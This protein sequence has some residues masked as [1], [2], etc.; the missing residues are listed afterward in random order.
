[1]K[2]IVGCWEKGE[3]EHSGPFCEKDPLTPV[4]QQTFHLERFKGAD[5]AISWT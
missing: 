5:I 1:M 2:K 3:R 4:D